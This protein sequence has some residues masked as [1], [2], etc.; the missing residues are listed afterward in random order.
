MLIVICGFLVAG[1]LIKDSYSNWIAS[2][3]YTTIMTQP[4][5]DLDFPTVTVCPPKDSYTALNY[6]L[7]KAD[8]NSLTEGDR[9]QLKDAVFKNIIQPSHANYIKTLL[10]TA[11]PENLRIMYEGFQSTPK[12]AEVTGFEV[13]MW[14]NSGTQKTPWFGEKYRE[15]YYKE[16]KYH[17]VVLELP[18][19]I[20]RMVGSG[21]LEIQLEVDTRDEEGWKEEVKVPTRPEKYIFFS[22][23]KTWEN[24]EVHCQGEGG[25]LASVHNDE[26]WREVVALTRGAVNWLGGRDQEEERIWKWSDGS[27]WGNTKWADGAGS[28][29]DSRN[30][31]VSYDGKLWDDPCTNTNIFTCRYDPTILRGNVRHSL[32]YTKEQLFK[33]FEVDYSYHASSQ[34][35]LD[36]CTVVKIRFRVRVLTPT[37]FQ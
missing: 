36:S 33:S 9:E 35:L 29:G 7:M 34:Q 10:A 30:C 26:E 4:I 15:E 12:P 17:R 2:P 24:A 32:T 18:N 13:K 1:F 20:D 6:D 28:R 23:K 31:A 19:N 27:P 21:S 14:N 25:H 5:D 8:N 22:E 16:D 37:D 3:I 11:N